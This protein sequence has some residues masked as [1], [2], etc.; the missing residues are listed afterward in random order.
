M[1]GMISAEAGLSFLRLSIW[2]PT[3]S[4]GTTITAVAIGHRSG[5]IDLRPTTLREP[6]GQRFQFRSQA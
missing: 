5:V 4:W 6:H 1:A 2:P 3:P